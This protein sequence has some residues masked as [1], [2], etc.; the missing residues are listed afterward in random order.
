MLIKA[1]RRDAISNLIFALTGHLVSKTL[2]LIE[3]QRPLNRKLASI[4]LQ[5]DSDEFDVSPFSPFTNL[6][7]N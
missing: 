6:V 3:T 5:L 2:R 4:G 7:I 1:D